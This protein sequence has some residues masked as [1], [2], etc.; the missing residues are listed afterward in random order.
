MRTEHDW[1]YGTVIRFLRLA[2]WLLCGMRVRGLKN[3]PLKGGFIIAS[4]HASFLDPP[5]IAAGIMS[6]IVHY[7]ARDT[8]F[9]PPYFA[10]FL[11]N[12]GVIPLDRARGDL[13]AIKKALHTLK[14]GKGIGLFPEGTRTEDGNLQPPKGG[15]GFIVAKAGVP[16]VP[17]YIEG[18]FRVWPKGQKRMKIGRR[19][20]IYYGD[21]IQPSELL[22]YGTGNEAYD[23]ISALIMERIARLKPAPPK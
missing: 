7:M 21:P 5:A 12:M 13:G 4:N 17:T 11:R 14:E 20:T 9:H 18:T 8:L 15:I 19:I 16:V 2:F 6:R 23:K 22:A 10:W 1:Y 3:V